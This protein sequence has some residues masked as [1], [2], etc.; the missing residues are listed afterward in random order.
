MSNKTQFKCSNVVTTSSGR[1]V[2]CSAFLMEVN[3]GVFNENLKKS[4]SIKLRCRKCSSLYNVSISDKG[5][6][7]VIRVLEKNKETANV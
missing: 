2:K 1:E 3:D 6:L 5:E 4:S 7:A